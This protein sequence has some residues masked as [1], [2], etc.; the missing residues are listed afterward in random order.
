MKNYPAHVKRSL[1]AVIKNMAKHPGNF[2][3][4]PGKDFTRNRRLPFEKVLSFLVKMGAHSLRDEML[5][6]LDFDNTP[7]TVSALVQQR[8]RGI[9]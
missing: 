4:R 8:R 5:D 2:C 3:H 6:C 9:L 1:N 7:A